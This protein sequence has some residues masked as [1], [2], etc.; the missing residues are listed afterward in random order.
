MA[1]RSA[2]AVAEMLAA[3]RAD[4]AVGLHFWPKPSPDTPSVLQLSTAAVV[5]QV[6]LTEHDGPALLQ[7]LAPLLEGDVLKVTHDCRA[8]SAAFALGGVRLN[9]VFDVQATYATLRARGSGGGG[10]RGGGR[11]PA[12]RAQNASLGW[13]VRRFLAA[14]A[15]SAAAVAEGVAPGAPPAELAALA[16]PL[17]PLHARLLLEIELLAAIATQRAAARSRAAARAA[18]AAAA[19]PPPR[20]RRARRRGSAALRRAARL[21]GRLRRLVVAALAP[22]LARRRV[23]RRVDA[24]GHAA[25]AAAAATPPPRRRGRSSSCRRRRHRCSPRRSPL[26]TRMSPRGMSVSRSAPPPS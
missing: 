8:A 24:V 20:R 17:L 6:E 5:Y 22:V 12:L 25:A 26:P 1:V 10:G 19:P 14:E 2:A 11:G 21:A 15:P 3:L 7:A 18:A 4:G 9:R 16:A 13:L 23:T